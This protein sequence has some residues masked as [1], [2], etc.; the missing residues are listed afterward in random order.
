MLVHRCIAISTNKWGKQNLE[1]YGQGEIV[2]DRLGQA[3]QGKAREDKSRARQGRV[4]CTLSGMS[5]GI[6]PR[7][8]PSISLPTTSAPRNAQ[9]N[10]RD[11][12]EE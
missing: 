1:V 7:Q 8:S 6:R 4:L 3:R 11:P 5:V 12:G 2:K 10:R 9:A